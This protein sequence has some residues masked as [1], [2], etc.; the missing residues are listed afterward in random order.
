MRIVC[1]KNIGDTLCRISQEERASLL[2]CGSK[3]QSSIFKGSVPDYLLKHS[4]VPVLVV[5]ADHNME[6]NA[7]PKSEEAA[8]QEV[9]VEEV[10]VEQ[11]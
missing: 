10:V 3:G 9:E 2:V 4:P 11:S 6:K 1:S 5:T 7:P 8:D